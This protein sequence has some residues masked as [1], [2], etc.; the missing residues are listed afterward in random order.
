MTTGEVTDA[1]FDRP[2][3]ARVELAAL[4]HNYREAERLAGGRRVL[5]VVK[6][7]A[8]GHGAVRV[9]RHL[10]G[11]GAH[12][13]G[14][15]LVEEGRELR[16]A[17]ITTPILVMGALFPGQAEALVRWDLTPALYTQAL[18]DS[19]VQA[20]RTFGK[21]VS[22]HVKVDTGMGR[23]GIPPEAASSFIAGLARRDGLRVEGIMT[24][25][26]DADLRD[27]QFASRQMDRFTAL[28]ADLDGRGISA[29]LRHAA[30]SAAVL[31]FSRALFTMVRPGLML[32]GYSPLEPGADVPHLRPA[33]SLV[34]Q[35]A[36]LKKVPP[37]TPVSYGR[38]F[39]TKRE[40]L[41]ATIP[42]GYADGYGRALSNR[43]EALVRGRRVPVAGRVCMDMTMLDVTD[44]PGVS[45]EDEVV[46]I[47][48]QGA[49]R[50]TANDIASVTGTI[51]YEVLCGIS[52]RVPRVY[53][54]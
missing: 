19:L 50:I 6:A 43:G 13:L 44:V 12:T 39:V 28:I 10:V 54:G 20:A 17:G 23:I 32:Y 4:T 2:T 14:V 38:T 30:N 5:A 34:T 41:I 29:P 25:F 26:A 11:L 42:I 21:I 3:T 8:Y 45:E 18:A 48:A 7:Q 16:E 36:Y 40:S 49:E 1:R 24:H 37:G 15:A 9:A 51:S 27:K 35:I 22:V 31:D 47:G 33:L 52:S 46:L 53:V